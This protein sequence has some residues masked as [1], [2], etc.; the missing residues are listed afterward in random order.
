MF[1][2]HAPFPSVIHDSE[3]TKAI[4]RAILEAGTPGFTLMMRAAQVSLERI[5]D[6]EKS[7]EKGFTRGMVVLAGPINEMRSMITGRYRLPREKGDE[8]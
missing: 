1:A 5:L 6:L 8:A 7:R 3:S 2:L 4:D